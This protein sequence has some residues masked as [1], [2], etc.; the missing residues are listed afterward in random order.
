M[1]IRAY[2]DIIDMLHVEQFTQ[3]KE[4]VII[5]GVSTDSRNINQGSL[6]IPLVGENFDGHLF[7]EEAFNKGA[8]ASLW[9]KDHESP[10]DHVPLI[11]VDDTL[12]ALQELAKQYMKQVEA[13]VI[14]ITGS[15]G[16]T[17]TKDMIAAILSTTYKVHKTEGNFN[18]QIGLPLTLLQMKEDTQFA[19]LEMGMSG[20]GEIDLLSK[21]AEPD[22]AIITNIGEAHLLQLGSR[23]EIAKA[24]LEIINGLKQDG[25]FI[26]PG[27]EPLL[28]NISELGYNLPPSTKRIR[29]GKKESNEIYPTFIKM[30]Q[31]GVYFGLNQSP[32]KGYYIPLIGRHNVM[33]A[34]AAIAVSELL[35][36]KKEDI[37]KG[38]KHLKVSSMRT[39]KIRTNS[40]FVI[41]NDA[42]NSSPNALKA[43]IEML[44]EL[45]GYHHKMIV[46][47]DMLELGENERELH[48][49]IG[50]RL[51]PHKIDYV[52][53]YGDLAEEVAFEA[54]NHYLPDHVKSFKN[55]EKLLKELLTIVT[56]KDVI[57]IKGSRGMKL[58]DI[59]D[60][61]KNR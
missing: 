42:Y 50:R 39:Q 24:K 60:E 34:I 61:L 56:E 3:I 44:E 31:D 21:L 17:T 35:A 1:M 57:L 33:N 38:L 59:V 12:L 29:F 40:G 27:D 15:N 11:F 23:E 2:D 7:V 47:G 18:N 26:Y 22:I 43:A 28:E 53:T 37:I 54:Q 46:L 52:F 49:D 51:D 41:I 4:P 10:P 19:V 36:I 45:E 5:Q 48:Q 32:P 9:Q 25:L 8:A 55:K 20:R 30:E 6:F 13:R 14:A 58:E 16:K